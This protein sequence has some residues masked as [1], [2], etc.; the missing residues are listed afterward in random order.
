MRSTWSAARIKYAPESG[1]KSP[2]SKCASLAPAIALVSLCLY[3][4][5]QKMADQPS[6]KPLDACDF[7][8]DGRSARPLVPGTVP[9]GYLKT[10]ISLWTGRKAAASGEQDPNTGLTDA[11]LRAAIQPKQPPRIDDKTRYA[12]FVDEFPFPITEPIVEHGYQRYMIYCVVCHDPLGTGYGKIVERGYTRPPSYH[13]DRLRNAPVGH[14]FAVITEG[15]GSMPSY[16]EQI[17]LRDRWAIVAYIRTLQASQ[18]MRESGPRTT[19][20]KPS[21]EP[22]DHTPAGG[23]LP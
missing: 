22:Q 19:E 12:E 17:P 1:D 5:Q 11:Q 4:C 2:R 13:I 3:G 6:Y 10:D 16:G 15:Y 20:P 21:D 23:K 18:H 8:L 14:L 7:F 9:R